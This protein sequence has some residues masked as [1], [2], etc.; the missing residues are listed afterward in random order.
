MGMSP[1]IELVGGRRV[2]ERVHKRFYDMVY[3]D[4]WLKQYFLHIGQDHIES[5]Q[6]D[7]MVGAMG[8]VKRYRGRKPKDAHPHIFITDELFDHRSALLRRSI[9]E[10]GVDDA[11][12]VRW[13]L[14]DEAFRGRLVKQSKDQCKPRYRIDPIIDIPRPAARFGSRKKRWKTG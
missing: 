5:Q 14:M 1:L 12:M 3:A 2:L 10:E 8:G 7:F 11:L 6:T 4:P 13:M 9:Q